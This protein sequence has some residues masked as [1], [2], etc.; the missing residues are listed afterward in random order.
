MTRE[1]AQF[2]LQAYR[3]SGED[4]HDPQFEEALALVRNDPELARWFASEQALDAAIAG[5]IHS[6][7]P[8]SNLGT[9][10]LLAR[11]VIRPRPWWRSKPTWIAAAASVALLIVAASLFLPRKSGGAEF[12]SFRGRMIEAS[13]DETDHIDVW[14]LETNE[15]KQWLLENG[16]DQN[17]VLP[18]G[19]ADKGIMGCKVLEWQGHRVTL[20]CL[21]FGDNHVDVFVVNESALPGVSLSATP[22]FGSARGLTTAAW[23]RNGKIY[24]LAGNVPASGLKQLL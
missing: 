10:L 16:G 18:P 23:R 3:P 12:A 9:Q 11:K 5:R 8:P 14:G 21:I 15:L 4:A 17:F 6:V 24:F 22:S 1:E 13:L 2:I 19:L 7:S 20:L